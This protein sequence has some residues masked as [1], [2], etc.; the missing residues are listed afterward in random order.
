MAH[1]VVHAVQHVLR[2]ERPLALRINGRHAQVARGQ[3]VCAS[4]SCLDVWS[5]TDQERSEALTR[6]HK[7]RL[8]HVRARLEGAGQAGDG[9]VTKKEFEK[10]T[11][12]SCL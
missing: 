9:D 7:V 2:A 5:K 6:V 1:E 3:H 10:D 8:Q 4:A 12:L 11:T